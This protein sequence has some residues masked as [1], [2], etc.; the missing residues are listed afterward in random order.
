[1]SKRKCRRKKPISAIEKERRK[2][3]AQKR[4]E[5]KKLENRRCIKE[6][7]TVAVLC[8][9]IL[10]VIILSA[11]S[12]IF[13]ILLLLIIIIFIFICDK[14]GMRAFVFRQYPENF[15]FA[16][17][18][19]NHNSDRAIPME[20]ASTFS[21]YALILIILE[22][23]FS[24][25]WTIIWL[26]CVIIGWYY[27]LTDGS[28]KYSLEKRAEFENSTLFLLITPAWVLLE[29]FRNIRMNYSIL[30][31]TAICCLTITNIYAVLHRGKFSRT[32][33]IFIFSAVCAFSGF[34][35]VN[36]NLDFSKPKEITVTI[37]NKD[38]FS[39]KNS[40]YYI[41]TSDWKNPDELIDIQVNYDTYHEL[42][43][44]NKVIIEIYN[45]SLGIEH[46]YY[47]E[48]ASVN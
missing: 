4:K 14:S 13:L 42:E 23:K 45:G 18:L 24:F 3:L 48:K 1:M 22:H 12:D 26:T 34:L 7:I 44:G 46:Y 15:P 36:K 19:K 21:Y 40:S 25:I 27:I 39:G 37:Q 28:E 33:L 32:T 16:E 6:F 43:S 17:N 47:K 2:I 5:R 31:F 41:Y 30:L 38:S 10:A 20:L 35:A 29:N 9:L 8:I 11:V